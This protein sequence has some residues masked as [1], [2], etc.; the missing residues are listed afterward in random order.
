M[1]RTRGSTAATTS[2]WTFRRPA[3]YPNPVATSACASVTPVLQRSG[4]GGASPACSQA[5][6]PETA[7]KTSPW[8]G[9]ATTPAT[10]VPSTSA[11]MLTAQ[12]ASPYR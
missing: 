3:S 8:A 9:A 4:T 7:V 5:P 12:S 2:P 1:S 11:A 10:T 6:P